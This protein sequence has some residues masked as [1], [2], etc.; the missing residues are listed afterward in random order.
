MKLKEFSEVLKA[1][2]DNGGTY[3]IHLNTNNLE[4]KNNCISGVEFNDLYFTN[5]GTLKTIHDEV[6]LLFDNENVKPICQK[7]NGTNVYPMEITSGMTI[8]VSKI[9]AIEEVEDPDDWFSYP[10]T[11]IINLYMLPETDDINGK[12]NI[13]SIGL[14]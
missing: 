9:E 8:V 6:L 2:N 13:I 1:H 14:R 5:C 3:Q 11:R 12:R 10:S 7:A 4:G